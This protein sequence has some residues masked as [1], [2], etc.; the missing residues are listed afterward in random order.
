MATKIYIDQ[1]HNPQNPNA[2]AE[3]NGYREQDLVYV[4]GRM[5]ADILQNYG[6]ETRLS[7]K[8]PAT[9]LGTSNATSLAARVNEANAWGADYFI[10]LHTNASVNPAA[11][12]SEAL[13]Y[14]LS[15]PA[16]P[17]A[18]SILEQLNLSTGLR[19]R[20]VV[21]RPGLY[22]LKKTRMPAVLIELGF[23]T[24]PNDA[25]LMANSPQLFA[26][27]V[28]DGIVD[29]LNDIESVANMNL[30]NLPSEINNVPMTTEPYP[31]SEIPIQN[32]NQNEDE[33]PLDTNETEYESY[34]DFIRENSRRGMLKVQ[35]SRAEQS[36]PVSGVKIRVSKDIGDREYVFF[37]GYTDRNG[38]ID[39][40]E[41]PAPP[42]GN[43]LSS[44]LPDKT[45]TY[46]LNADAPSYLPIAID[47][48]MYEGIKTIQPL[49]MML[50]EED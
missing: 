36:I 49:N 23:I 40:I 50:E 30:Y 8:T 10:S 45:V 12:G 44:S 34:T 37:E 48:N 46:L 27:G 16:H 11:S 7:R 6:F 47:I 33:T 25:S 18:E 39:G 20:G 28:A 22:I 38:M 19:D 42:R 2:G 41:L 17:L 9:Q 32:E 5:L 15:S 43:S 21:P 26:Q 35:A 24:N 4:I 13:V 1:G 3:G 29:Y 31:Q 14:S